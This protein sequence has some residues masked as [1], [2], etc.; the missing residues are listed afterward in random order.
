MT[1]QLTKL[2]PPNLLSENDLALGLDK[3]FPDSYIYNAGRIALPTKLPL[4]KTTSQISTISSVFYI[5]R[6]PAPR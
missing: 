6:F 5:G 4:R 2:K 1:E 3:L